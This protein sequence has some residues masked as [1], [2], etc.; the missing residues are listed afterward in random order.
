MNR[1]YFVL[2]LI[3]LLILLFAFTINTFAAPNGSLQVSFINVGQ[4][5][6]ALIQDQNGFDVLI[7]GGKSSAGPTVVGYLRDQGVDDVDVMVA[8]HADSDHIGGLIDVLEMDDIPV[9]QVIYNGYPGDTSTWFEFATAVANEGLSLTAAQYPLIYT[10]GSVS[11]HILNPVSGLIDPDQNDASV[12]ILLDHNNIEFLFTGDIS[13]IEEAEIVARGTP[14]AAE[15]LKVPHH[16]S[17]Y[18]ASA[19]FLSEVQPNE[20]VISVGSNS[21]G[22]PTDETLTRLLSAGAR[23]WRTDESGTILVTSDG[24]TYSIIGE[25]SI[26]GDIFLPLIIR[27]TPEP[28]PTPTTPPPPPTTQPP[29]PTTEPPPPTTQPPPPTTEPPPPTTQPPPVTTGNVQ[30]IN[31][32]VDGAGSS[33]PDEYVEIRNDDTNSIQLQNW[34]LRDIADHI[35]TFPSFVMEPGKVCRV[36]T[37]ENHPEWCGFNYGS[38]SA[39]WNNGGDTA[40]LRDGNGT[41]I[42]D[43]SY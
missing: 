2:I 33:E 36:Y 4:G 31:I 11:A 10:W 29:P 17:K 20:A 16:G 22:H 27:S 21:Y 7:D 9:Q 25:I 1:R 38:G 6:S 8:S 42:D 12:V 28:L 13:S 34:T 40:Y 26:G 3:T 39:I 19:D 14:V 35:F 24:D 18:S 32:F 37:N 15:I 43:Y 41:P 23:I 30:I 5:D